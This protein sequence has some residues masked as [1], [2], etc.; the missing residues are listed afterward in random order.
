MRIGRH[1]RQILLFVATILVPGAV[2]V[3]MSSRMV[4]QDQELAA[5]RLAGQKRAALDQLR[6]ELE[7]RLETIKLEEINR[8]IRGTSPDENSGNPAIIFTAQL[9]GDRLLMPWEAE[10]PPEPAE[11]VRHR[12]E[13]ESREF[14][15]KDFPGAVAQYRLALSAASVAQVPRVRMLLARALAKSGQTDEATRIYKSLLNALPDARDDLGVGVRFY[16]AERL[17]ASGREKDA[18]IAFLRK[19]VEGNGWITLPELYLIRPLIPAASEPQFNRRL[20]R[21]EEAEA[22]TKDVTRL[23]ARIES[24]ASPSGTVWVPYVPAAESQTPWLVTITD[25]QPPLPGL[26]LAVASDKVAPPGVQLQAVAS[27]GE[28]VGEFFPGLHVEWL[29]PRSLDAGS[30]PLPM[31]VVASVWRWC[32]AL[33]CSARISRYAT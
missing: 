25:P 1:K 7:A 9:E 10:A 19:Q 12:E 32:S 2:L 29:D 18:A 16:A 21:M 27:A 13:G 4:Y 15:S 30:K 28:P 6:R 26:L 11:F 3:G 5:A 8:R 20:A 31:A 23:R 17:L 14:A 24:V 22:L 33:P